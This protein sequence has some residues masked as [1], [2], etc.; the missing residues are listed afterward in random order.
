MLSIQCYS[1]Q[2]SLTGQLVSLGL[3]YPA[4]GNGSFCGMLKGKI[5]TMC[6]PYDSLVEIVMMNCLSLRGRHKNAM[7]NQGHY[8]GI[9]GVS[10]RFQLK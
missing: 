5:C 6:E 3:F 2:Q 9:L 4:E 8:P 7:T 10:G 1:R